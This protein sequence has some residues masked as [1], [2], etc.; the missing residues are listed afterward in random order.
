MEKHIP[1]AL[2]KPCPCCNGKAELSDMEV[3]GIQ[4]WQVHCNQ[5]GLSSEL[6][7]DMEFSVQ[8]WNR[9]LELDKV[10][11][12]LTLA[13]STVPLAAI[14]AFLAGSYLGLRMFS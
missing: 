12:W 2:L 7:E 9:R 3:S 10:R 1:F 5:C 4:M 6:D 13:T 14:L 8:C 11:M